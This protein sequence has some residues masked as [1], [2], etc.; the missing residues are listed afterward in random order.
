MSQ[1]VGV[2]HGRSDG[3]FPVLGR[4]QFR[5]GFVLLKPAGVHAGVNLEQPNVLGC[6]QRDPK[7]SL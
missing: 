4:Q 1:A 2:I 6:A 7:G 5:E 3:G